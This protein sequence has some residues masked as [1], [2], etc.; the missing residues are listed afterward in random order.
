MNQEQPQRYKIESIT[1]SDVYLRFFTHDVYLFVYLE[2]LTLANCTDHCQ[3]RSGRSKR[4]T[5]RNELN[6]N[7][8]NQ[9]QW[10]KRRQYSQSW[11]HLR[12]HV[13]FVFLH[14]NIFIS[15][16]AVIILY[17]LAAISLSLSLSKSQQIVCISKETPW[18]VVLKHQTKWNLLLWIMGENGINTF[19]PTLKTT[20]F[21]LLIHMFAC[22]YFR[23]ISYPK[24]NFF[25][26]EIRF[27]LS[28]NLLSWNFSDLKTN[29][30]N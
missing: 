4:F 10:I 11:P 16:V 23:R 12:A 24:K 19:K 29:I 14:I 9:I 27:K 28:L 25:Q 22:F 17:I 6:I 20:F 2:P 7:T 30:L 5:H 13:S 26:V 8:T 1:T 15:S 18:C 3:K 21:P